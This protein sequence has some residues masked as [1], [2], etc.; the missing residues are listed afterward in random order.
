MPIT[1]AL[2]QQLQQQTGCTLQPYRLQTVSGGDINHA[3][4]LHSGSQHWFI[5]CNRA[6]RLAMFQAEAAGLQALAAT[7]TVNTP[8]LITLGQT[9]TCSYLVLAYHALQ[10]L[11]NSSARQLGEQLAQLHRIPQTAYG[12][13]LNNT[14]GSTPQDN[15]P[16]NDW[17]DFW[18]QQR[19]APQLQRAAQQGYTGALQ[20]HG[21]QLLE[22][23]GGFFDS[24]RPQPAL[25]HGDLWG[26]NA[27]ADSQGR[28]I[29]YDPACYIGDRETDLA[30]TQLFGGF[31]PDF[32]AAYNADWPLDAGYRARQTLYNLY[33][34]LNH[35]NLFGRSYLNQAI[36]MMHQLLAELG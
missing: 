10:P 15:S 29:V 4:Q 18:Q 14:L 12:W 26:G 28:A 24:Y 6:D 16:Q 21:Q 2:I 25:L 35:L 1:A 27:A 23:L 22:T 13:H 33:H 8:R 17:V 34:V 36:A 5:K 9:D 19:L 7:H 31:P 32:Y 3:Y 20:Q 11:T 30:M